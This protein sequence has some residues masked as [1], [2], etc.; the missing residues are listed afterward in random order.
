MARSRGS[1]PKRCIVAEC[2]VSRSRGELLRASFVTARDDDYYRG[3]DKSFYVSLVRAVYLRTVCLFCSFI[4]ARLWVRCIEKF[5][6][7]DLSGWISSFVDVYLRKYLRKSIPDFE[8]SK[9]L[10]Y[11]RN[12]CTH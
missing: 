7:L 10:N 6:V 3:A 1:M 12:K 2:D 11:I 8:K 5:K 4:A 9:L